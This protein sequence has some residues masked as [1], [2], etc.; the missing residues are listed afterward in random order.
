MLF[1]TKTAYCYRTNVQIRAFYLKIDQP[2]IYQ[3]YTQLDNTRTGRD[4][5]V[6]LLYFIT[7]YLEHRVS[8]LSP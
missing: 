6:L 5:L 2:L 7:L 3:L 4:T 8:C 1:E